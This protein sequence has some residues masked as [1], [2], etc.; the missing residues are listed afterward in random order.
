MK[1]RMPMII[2]FA[3]IQFVAFFLDGSISQMFSS[4]LFNYPNEMVTCITLL[5]LVLA[6][7]FAQFSIYK[8]VFWAAL[9]GIMFDVYY[10]GLLGVY[11]FIYP[12]VVYISKVVYDTMPR[13]LLS[14]LMVYFID[15][16]MVVGMGYFANVLVGVTTIDFIMFLANILAPTLVINLIFLVLLYFPVE[17]LYMAHRR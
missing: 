1:K 12:L 14:G 17:S 5:W 2:I 10:T 16:T 11:V 6:T 4:M 9:M 8:I 15:V 7:F 3:F 13:N